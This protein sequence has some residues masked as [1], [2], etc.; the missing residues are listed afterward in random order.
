MRCRKIWNKEWCGVRGV[1][2]RS[3]G[4]GNNDVHFQCPHRYGMVMT[5][6]IHGWKGSGIV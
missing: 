1:H 3:R 6:E 5:V 2:E 4:R